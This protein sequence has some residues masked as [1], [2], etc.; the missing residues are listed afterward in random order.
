MG[1]LQ[2]KM[3]TNAIN[4]LLLKYNWRQNI[5]FIS[6][7]CLFA[8]A[9][10][11]IDI[12][13]LESCF[14][15]EQST[16]HQWTINCSSMNN[17]LFIN[18]QSTV[19]Q[20]TINCSSMNNQLFNYEQSTGQ[21]WTIICSTMNN[22]LFNYEQSTV[23]LLYEQSSVQLWTINCSTIIKKMIRSNMINQLVKNVQ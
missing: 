2:Y 19:H 9:C 15:Y 7:N 10:N 12:R 22:Q 3:L 5:C 16:V 1:F 18:E 8:F 13:C 4:K 6:L 23:Q 11:M 17:Q 20:W 14:D 21:L